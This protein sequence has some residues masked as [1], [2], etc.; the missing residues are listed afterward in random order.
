[1]NDFSLGNHENPVRIEDV[2]EFQKK[3]NITSLP[4]EYVKHVLLKFN[5]GI[6][7]ADAYLIDVKVM[8][9]NS[10]LE[11]EIFQIVRFY[12]LDW[13]QYPYNNYFPGDDHTEAEIINKYKKYLFIAEGTESNL[14]I[15]IYP[16]NFDEIYL[17]VGGEGEDNNP[18]KVSNSFLEFIDMIEVI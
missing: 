6:P 18:Y 14:L 13:L 11:S 9:V 3:H 5:G 1:M 12:P 10:I 7:L 16:D 15:G 17:L 4:D 8:S 2:L